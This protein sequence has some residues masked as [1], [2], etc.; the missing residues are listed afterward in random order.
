MYTPSLGSQFSIKT[1]QGNI[2]LWE[3]KNTGKPVLFLHGNSACAQAFSKQ[4]DSLLAQKYRFIAADLPG[5]GI[6]DPA[7]D[8]ENTYNYEG[9]AKVFQEVIEQLNFQ[10]PLTVVG[11][12]LG[13]HVGLS[14]IKRL[15]KLAGLLITGT[16]PSII[17]EGGRQKG[18]NPMPEIGHLFN[19]IA[20]DEMDADLFMAHGGFN[21]KRDEFIVQ[22]AMKCDGRARIQNG[23]WKKNNTGYSQ[24]SVV[25]NDPTPICV[26][27]GENDKGIDSEYIRSIPFKN[28][29][30]NTIHIIPKAAHAAFRECPEDFNRILE[31]FL[32]HVYSQ[33]LCSD[34]KAELTH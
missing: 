15:Q 2:Q 12:S 30:N 23:E 9:Y 5:H 4:F 29:F 32:D 34:E 31:L 7:T 16:P 25:E 28:L 17:E 26:V 10:E 3:S 33:S 6:S 24:R 22:A 21:T 19:K 18:F 14:M 1:S 20:F 8:P 27:Q 11:W 13:G